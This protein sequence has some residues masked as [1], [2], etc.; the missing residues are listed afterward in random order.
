MSK[1]GQRELVYKI[2]WQKRR[3]R[4]SDFCVTVEGKPKENT[5]SQLLPKR[6][7]TTA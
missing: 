6:V 3:H 2:K 7:K 1:M 5:S 4:G